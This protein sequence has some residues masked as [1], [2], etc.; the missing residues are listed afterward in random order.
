MRYLIEKTGGMV[1]N[2]EE[3]V[4]DVFSHSFKKYCEY[5]SDNNSVY[6]AKLTVQCSKELYL[7]GIL[8][9]AKLINKK[10]FPKDG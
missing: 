2:Q 8:G 9:P 3:F 6:F 10:N 1:I 5:I 7:Q 4:L